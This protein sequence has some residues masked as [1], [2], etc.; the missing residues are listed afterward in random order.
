MRNHSYQF[1]I[2]LNIILVLACWHGITPAGADVIG[3]SGKQIYEYYCYQCHGYDGNANTTAAQSVHP[4]PVKFSA[5]SIESL[6]RDKMISTLKSGIPGT[7]MVSFRRVLSNAEIESVVEY[8]RSQFMSG[9]NPSVKYHSARNG[10]ISI[11]RSASDLVLES[12]A[13]TLAKPGTTESPSKSSDYQRYRSTCIACHELENTENQD[14]IW[15]LY[16]VSFPVGNYEEDGDWPE[17]PIATYELHEHPVPLNDADPSAFIGAELYQSMCAH[18]HAEDASGQNWIGAF[19]NPQPNDIKASPLLLPGSE[20]Q[21]TSVIING[22][23]GTSMPAWKDVL[24]SVQVSQL[25]AYLKS[26]TTSVPRK[27][28]LSIATPGPVFNGTHSH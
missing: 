13:L 24:D 21:L 18:C 26:I 8:I 17:S 6:P 9:T 27:S 7:A 20:E 22:I 14:L 2:S 12:G 25:L 5:L 3:K 1:G 10:W 4:K 15:Q 11:D 23:P 16:S 28:P 19:L